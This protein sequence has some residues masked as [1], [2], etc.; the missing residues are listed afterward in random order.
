M[1]CRP[2]RTN[3]D[4]GAAEVNI[5]SLRSTSQHFQCLNSQ[6]LLYYIISPNKNNNN[7]VLTLDYVLDSL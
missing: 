1:W 2:G 4:F 5:G 3:I 7:E 6:Q